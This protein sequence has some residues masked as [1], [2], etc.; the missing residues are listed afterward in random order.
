MEEFCECTWKGMREH[1]T[2][3][4]LA[5]MQI[6]AAE[7]AR[8]REISEAAAKKCTDRIPASIFRDQFV[9]A[10]A[11]DGPS[12]TA[13]CECLWPQLTKTVTRAQMNDPAF[14]SSP[15]MRNAQRESAKKCSDKVPTDELRT[16]FMQRCMKQPKSGPYCEC[17]WKAVQS[18]LNLGE[19]I[20]LDDEELDPILSE[21]A[22][23]CEKKLP[24]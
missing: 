13:F 17:T 5:K 9:A 19:M 12:L 21:S 24:K 20:V 1:V 2:D 11:K 8:L 18:K 10:C 6:E 3:E 4:E 15:A 7:A 22:A 16:V 14:V 23:T